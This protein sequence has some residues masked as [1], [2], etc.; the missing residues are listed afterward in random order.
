MKQIPDFVRLAGIPK[1]I[2]LKD[3]SRPHSRLSVRQR[4]NLR[5]AV[6]GTAASFSAEGGVNRRAL[7]D[8][9]AVCKAVAPELSRN[10]TVSSGTDDDETICDWTIQQTPDGS[11]GGLGGLEPSIRLM[12]GFYPVRD[13][14]KRGACFAFAMTALCEYMLRS[15]KIPLS[16]QSLFVFTKLA[17]PGLVDDVCDGS[18]D[19]DTLHAVEQFGICPQKL[20]HYNPESW[21]WIEDPNGEGAGTALERILHE[22]RP[23]RFGPWRQIPSGSV[24]SLKQA[25][26]EG[27]PIYV[28]V[29][30]FPFWGE[31][32]VFRT[33]IVPCPGDFVVQIR[34]PSRA[35]VSRWIASQPDLDPADVNLEDVVHDILVEDFMTIVEPFGPGIEVIGFEFGEDGLFARFLSHK[36]EGGHALCL[37]GYADDSRFPGG[38]YFIA[39]NSWSEKWAPDSP[40]K[41]GYA[42]LSYAYIE[43]YCLDGWYLP[44]WPEPSAAAARPLVGFPAVFPASSGAAAGTNQTAASGT[45]FL[46]SGFEGKPEP[47]DGFEAWLSPRTSV[48]SRPV[49]D[50]T[51]VLLRPGTRVLVPDPSRPDTVYRDTPQHRAAM[52]TLFERQK[53]ASVDDNHVRLVSAVRDIADEAFESERWVLSPEEI[54]DSLASAGF[55]GVKTKDIRTALLALQATDSGTYALCLNEYGHEELRQA[56]LL[57]N[58]KRVTE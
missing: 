43:K 13:Q 6:K 14:S 4:Q 5:S 49:R 17:T 3:I 12:D 22:A 37:A 38:G 45:E 40:E 8:A 57:G 44:D 46:Q 30:V 56:V 41:A 33:G 31:E 51:G 58:R 42:I 15:R 54:R 32:E 34:P 19:V 21:N 10:L 11:F 24:L 48:L 39:R 25:L 27:F 28:G 55:A 29:F 16:E 47:T 23:Y 7:T 9:L 50:A 52:K 36:I 35:A 26:H 20:W 53:T 2:S 1:G 18:V